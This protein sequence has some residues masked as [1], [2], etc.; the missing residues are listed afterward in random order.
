MQR[1]NDNL[2]PLKE[3]GLIFKMK[4]IQT[5]SIP[6][7]KLVAD[8]QVINK[9]QI[10]TALDKMKQE[11]IDADSSEDEEKKR[12]VDLI[13]MGLEEK[14][15]HPRVRYLKVDISIDEQTQ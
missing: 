5:A 14:T 11:A 10:T 2:L 3:K 7:I 6:I 8:L 13:S 9:Q 4:F 12:S 15:I 1:L